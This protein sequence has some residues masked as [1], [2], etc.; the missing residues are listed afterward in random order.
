MKRISIM[1]LLFIGSLLVTLLYSCIKE[2]LA[3]PMPATKTTSANNMNFA[4][5]DSGCTICSENKEVV[6]T[7]ANFFGPYLG[8]GVEMN[9]KMGSA[10]ISDLDVQ[11]YQK[12]NV[13]VMDQ[14]GRETAIPLFTMAA[15]GSYESIAYKRGSSFLTIMYVRFN[16]STNIFTYKPVNNLTVK[17][18][19]SH[20]N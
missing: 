7:S 8:P 1:S 3:D 17:Y 13:T 15:D 12:L 2:G 16:K 9:S 6:L 11:E 18:S 5:P 10:T 20:I 19:L 4:R 14:G